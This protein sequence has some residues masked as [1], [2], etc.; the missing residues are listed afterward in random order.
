M[1]PHGYSY[2]CVVYIYRYYAHGRFDSL[3]CSAGSLYVPRCAPYIPLPSWRS[4]WVGSASDFI[5]DFLCSEPRIAAI[6]TWSKPCLAPGFATLEGPVVEDNGGL[7]FAA[8]V[9]NQT[10]KMKRWNL[11]QPALE[12]H[13]WH[14][15]K[16][17]FGDSGFASWFL[18]V[19]FTLP[20]IREPQAQLTSFNIE[21]R[22]NI[23]LCRVQAP[24]TSTA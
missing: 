6:S 13:V 15:E 19:C 1:V 9:D 3:S 20:Q 21:L 22:K 18:E 5:H 23:W 4:F 7:H 8:L 12:E 24:N 2:I 10:L 11:Q 14:R 17:R 16:I